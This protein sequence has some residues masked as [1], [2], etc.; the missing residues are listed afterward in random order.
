MNGPD[1]LAFY[2]HFGMAVAVKGVKTGCDIQS[3]FAGKWIKDL[4]A[5]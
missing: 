2:I 5:V 3:G 1:M 4:K